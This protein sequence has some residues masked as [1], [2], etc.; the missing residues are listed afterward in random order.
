MHTNKPQTIYSRP[1]HYYFKAPLLGESMKQFA[2][3]FCV[4]EIP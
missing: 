4:L 1:P 2:M 3:K